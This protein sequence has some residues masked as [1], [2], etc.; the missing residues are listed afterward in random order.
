MSDLKPCPFCG[1]DD[2]AVFSCGDMTCRNESCKA[3]VE[4]HIDGWQLRP[5]E[6]ALRTQLA[7]ANERIVELER[8]CEE[9]RKAGLLAWAGN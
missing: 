4:A 6:D 9:L 5:I 8:K 3:A 1:T 2:P 7:A